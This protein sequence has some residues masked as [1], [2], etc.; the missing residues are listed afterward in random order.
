[1]QFTA[2]QLELARWA[3]RNGQSE[4]SFARDN[5]MRINDVK[6][7]FELA[8]SELRKEDGA[9]PN[10]VKKRMDAAFDFLCRNAEG[11]DLFFTECRMRSDG[12]PIKDDPRLRSVLL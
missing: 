11:V 3:L 9:K 5:G 6:W 12:K 7:L 10:D 4:A 2:R 1:M 8:A